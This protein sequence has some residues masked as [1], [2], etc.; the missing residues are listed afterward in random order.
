MKWV[1]IFTAAI[2]GLFLTLTLIS[3]S[4]VKGNDNNDRNRG[5]RNREDEGEL[6]VRVGFAI[7]PIPFSSLSLKGKDP[8]LAGLGSYIVNAQ[9]VV[10][11]A[12]PA[13]RMPQDP[14]HII[15]ILPFLETGSLTAKTIWLV[16]CLSGRSSNPAI[17]PRMLQGNLLG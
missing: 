4:R 17:S 7:S 5:D 1:I 3:N 6:E 16:E 2:V 10:T 12:I 14:H 11:I 8:E 13:L 15:H 9:G